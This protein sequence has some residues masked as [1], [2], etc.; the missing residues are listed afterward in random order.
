MIF[1]LIGTLVKIFQCSPRAKAWDK[2]I[3][4]HCLG[5]D[6]PIL[7]AAAINVVSDCLILLLPM[8]SV[9]RLHMK[10]TRKLGVCAI[11]LAGSL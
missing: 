1:Y 11:F 10:M 8:V 7:V 6:V 2:S 9:W 3:P 4:G 5:V